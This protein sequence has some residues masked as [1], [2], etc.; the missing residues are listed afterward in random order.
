MK[1]SRDGKIYKSGENLGQINNR[2]G[3]S[4]PVH[5]TDGNKLRVPGQKN[6]FVDTNGRRTSYHIKVIISF[7]PI[8]AGNRRDKERDRDKTWQIH[9]YN[10]ALITFSNRTNGPGR[11]FVLILRRYTGRGCTHPRPSV[12]NAAC[13]HAK[14]SIFRLTGLDSLII[15]YSAAG[16][17]YI[18]LRAGSTGKSSP[19][20][21]I[22]CHDELRW[23]LIARMV[24]EFNIL[25]WNDVPRTSRIFFVTNL[26]HFSQFQG[27]ILVIRL[28]KSRRFWDFFSKET[29]V[30]FGMQFPHTDLFILEEY[31][32]FFFKRN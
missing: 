23:K 1:T 13:S 32:Q 19:A 5:Q 4:A 25:P 7:L 11:C 21:G 12:V 10:L 14:H 15:I 22:D 8:F 17:V 20:R 2:G 18:L 3:C 16:Y 9:C 29:T 27:G 26:Q 28:E 6:A 24:G 31:L 30:H